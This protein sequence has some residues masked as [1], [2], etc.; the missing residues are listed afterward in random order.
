MFRIGDTV[1]C[2]DNNNGSFYHITVGKTYTVTRV[3]SD[4]KIEVDGGDNAYFPHR[5]EFVSHLQS[6]FQKWE[7]GIGAVCLA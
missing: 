2:V 3:N 6:P 5:F 1:R 4:G 7:K